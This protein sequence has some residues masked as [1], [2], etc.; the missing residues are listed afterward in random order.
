MAALAS[1]DFVLL[2]KVGQLTSR[3]NTEGKLPCSVKHFPAV[4]QSEAMTGLPLTKL[5]VECA[6][7]CHRGAT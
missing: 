6:D 7:A 2:P 4:K 1:G 3:S 5:L